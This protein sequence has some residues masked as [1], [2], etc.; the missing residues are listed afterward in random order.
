MESGLLCGRAEICSGENCQGFAHEVLKF[1]HAGIRPPETFF[2][3]SLLKLSNLLELL[4]FIELR[5]KRCLIEV[6]HDLRRT[7]FLPRLVGGQKLMLGAGTCVL[8]G[9]SEALPEY[10]D[11]DV[12]LGNIENGI[13][14]TLGTLRVKPGI[15]IGLPARKG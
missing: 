13:N 6:N 3:E 12:A 1:V 10:A 8:G 2:R 5:Q 7:I 15:G 4:D 9:R 11:E 14:E